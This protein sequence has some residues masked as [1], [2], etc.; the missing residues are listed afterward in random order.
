ML[1]QASISYTFKILA[2][3]FG[4]HLMQPIL[5]NPQLLAIKK[6]KYNNSDIHPPLTETN[7]SKKDGLDKVIDH[8]LSVCKYRYTSIHTMSVSE[9]NKGQE[10]KENYRSIFSCGYA[11]HNCSGRQ[12]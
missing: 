1:L 5:E 6:S 2:M 12:S 9:E 8:E 7:Q 10:N 11:E 3:I 4:T